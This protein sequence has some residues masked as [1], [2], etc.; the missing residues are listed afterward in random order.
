MKQIQTATLAILLLLG[1]PAFGA[2]QVVSRDAEVALPATPAAIKG[3]LAARRFTLET[4]FPYTWTKEPIMVST[5]VL[6]VLEVDPAYVVPRDTLEPVLYAGNVPVQ[7]LNHGHRSGR[8]IGIVPG[9]IDLASTPIWFGSPELPE[10]VT[11]SI[12][13]SE[14]TLAEKIGV[15]ALP[16]ARINAVQRPPVIAK[17]LA[18]LLRTVAADLVLEFSPQEKDLAESWR[19]PVAK[20]PPKKIH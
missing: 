11:P 3:I 17:D 15:H 13:Q 7:R 2:G 9:N 10:R 14:R 5:G 4:P 19:L 1:I 20:A 18:T 16:K 8:V 6:V 12:A